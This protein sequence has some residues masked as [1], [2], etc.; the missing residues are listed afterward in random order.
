MAEQG[1]SNQRRFMRSGPSRLSA[2]LSPDWPVLGVALAELLLSWPSWAHRKFETLELLDEQVARRVVTVDFSVP[3]QPG[4]L[5]INGQPYHFLPLTSLQKRTLTNF[6]LVLGG[7]E[8]TPM[9]SRSEHKELVT[10]ALVAIVEAELEAPATQDLRSR[11]REV[12]AKPP[13]KAMAAL[14]AFDEDDRFDDDG[15]VLRMVEILAY[16]F[17]VIA[18]IP[19]EPGCRRTAHFSYDEWI[20]DPKLP[21]R[22]TLETGAG[23]RSKPVWFKAA[24]TNVSSY[25]LQVDAPAG[26]QITRRQLV[27]ADRIRPRVAGPARRARFY[28]APTAK[29]G[30][31]YALVHL[32]P[33]TSTVVRGAALTAL[34]STVL[35]AVLAA[36]TYGGTLSKS[37]GAAPALVAA[38]P[39]VLA[40]L[41]VRPGEHPMTTDMLFSMRLITLAVGVLDFTAGAILA[42]ARRGSDEIGLVF[43]G[44]AAVAGIIT[45]ILIRTWVACHKPRGPRAAESRAAHRFA[46]D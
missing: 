26:L 34:L 28:H 16:Q 35:L 24:M 4:A 37:T 2:P 43:Y 45:L 5:D 46:G 11:C 41:L 25:H 32:R 23:W 9:A 20:G 3:D 29:S 30:N 39:G 38:A 12:V 19:A 40:L 14:R 1:P 10:E 18:L 17:L 33:L 21:T 22:L 7:G 8:A 44:L 6:D 36:V 42:L 31:A 15:E 27:T 13:E